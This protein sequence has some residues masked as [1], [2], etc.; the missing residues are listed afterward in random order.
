[1]AALP[2]TTRATPPS[3]KA[4]TTSPRADATADL[5]VQVRC[6]R[7]FEDQAAIGEGA[8]TRTVEVDQMQPARAGVA[9]AAH[10]FARIKVIDRLL[11]EVPA[12]QADTQ[13]AAKID[14]GNQ[15]HGP[16]SM[17]L[18]S[19]RAPASPERSGWNCTPRK[20]FSRTTDAN[21]PP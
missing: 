14:G 18:A 1:M 5:Q 4:S 11:P 3:S 20:F 2:T 8:V 21:S 13:S 7:E 15:Q 19:R 6:R 9:I 10:E 12:Q 16:S 17:K